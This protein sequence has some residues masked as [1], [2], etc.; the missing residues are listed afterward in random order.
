MFAHRSIGRSKMHTEESCIAI[1]TQPEQKILRCLL[2]L[3]RVLTCPIL[4][5]PKHRWNLSRNHLKM[6]VNLP[7]SGAFTT[8]VPC[9][10]GLTLDC[11][12]PGFGYAIPSCFTELLAF[13]PQ[14][15]L[16]TKCLNVLT[17]IQM[18]H[19]HT[20]SCLPHTS[21]RLVRNWPFL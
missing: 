20:C 6:M 2:S 18:G 17:V 3:I 9:C 16:A 13:L 7:Q 14:S 11:Q 12:V 10:W 5:S 8:A 4:T 19:H 1:H 15:F 21:A